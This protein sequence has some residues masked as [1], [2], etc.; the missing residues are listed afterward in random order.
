MAW[1]W[2]RVE[3]RLEE[4]RDVLRRLPDPHMKYLRNPLHAR[5]PDVVLNSMDNWRTNRRST[6]V[7]SGAEIDRMEQVIV[8]NDVMPPWLSLLSRKQRRL[9]WRR[10]S[11]YRWWTLA[12]IENRSERTVQRWYRESL[13]KIADEL[14][15]I[16]G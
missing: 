15:T 1:T 13:E 3:H 9:V 7:P 16:D 14:T 12:G 5:M 4:A 11:G 2:R 6:A 8:G 10:I